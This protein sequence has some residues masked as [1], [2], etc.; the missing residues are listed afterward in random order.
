M[1]AD[2]FFSQDVS[3]GENGSRAEHGRN[4]DRNESEILL[5][6]RELRKFYPVDD[7]RVYAIVEESRCRGWR[8]L[9]AH[10]RRDARHRRRI[11]L[12]KDDACADAAA[13]RRT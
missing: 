5:E 11:R 4:A 9:F 1:A 12:R 3:H 10:A 6:A 7:R 2:S 13:A 8:E